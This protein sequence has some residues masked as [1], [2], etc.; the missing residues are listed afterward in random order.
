MRTPGVEVRP[1]REITGTSDFN[2]VFLDSVR[3]PAGQVIGEVNDG[4]RVANASLAHERS[5]VGARAVEL[6]AQ[7]DDLFALARLA[8]R[9][10][11]AGPGRQRHPAA[12]GQARRPRP[13]HRRDE[14]VRAVPHAQRH[15]GPRRRRRSPRSSTARSTWPSPSSASPCKA[16]DGIAVE[17]DEQAYADGWWQDAFLYARAYTIA[18]GA[19]EVLK[20]V[21]A[22]RAL[23]LPR[24]RR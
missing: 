8:T 16:S 5:G 11:S 7:L 9:R 15:R 13:R 6:H 2:E 10:R 18:G 20:T 17:G 21:V 1:L 14:Q 4:W 19:N 12:A 3:I 22:E 23:G 24:D